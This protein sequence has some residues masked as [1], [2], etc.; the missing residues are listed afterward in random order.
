[1]LSSPIDSLDTR[2]SEP[3]HDRMVEALIAGEGFRRVAAIAAEMTGAEVEVLVPRPGSEGS[4]GSANERFAAALVAGGLP[5]W[6]AGVSEVVPIV[7]DGVTQGAVVASG[8]L[9]PGAE[10]HL[11]SA[12]RAAL[13]GIAILNTREQVRRDA[14]AGLVADLVTGRPPGPGEVGRRAELLGCDL[15]HGFLAFAGGGPR[16][17]AREEIAA[18]LADLHPG[19]LSETVAGTTYALVP[20][21]GL[22]GEELAPRIGA[23]VPRAHSSVYEDP[24]DAARALDEAR[25]L[26]ALART[27]IVP[28]TDRATWDSLRLMHGAFAS[29]PE[30]LRAFCERTVGGLVRVDAEEDGRLQS[31]F[32]AY[33]EA[34]CNMNLAAVRLTTHRHT[35]GNR[36]RRIQRLTGLDPQRGYD[37]DLL[38]MALRAHLVI[39]ESERR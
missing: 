10:A 9:A 8:E 30:R 14:A 2:A 3:S 20:G 25:T 31:T 11:R 33:Q 4:D 12:A 26:L 34:N 15:R 5:P 16:G 18:A 29:E 27:S 37:R 17:G 36:L 1:M 28:N 23:A 6:P 32:W 21:T 24:D 7:I 39:A 35:V 13:T 19:A 38:G 22:R